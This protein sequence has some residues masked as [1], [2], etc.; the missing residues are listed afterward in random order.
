MSKL[1]LLSAFGLKFLLPRLL[2]KQLFLV[3]SFSNDMFQIEDKE[4]RGIKI[5]SN[6]FSFAVSPES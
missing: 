1:H 5:H 3:H 4:Y 2:K 6:E